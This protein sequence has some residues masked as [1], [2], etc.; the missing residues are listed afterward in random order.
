MGALS[1]SGPGALILL[2]IA[3][4]VFP[5]GIDR[6]DLGAF[7]ARESGVDSRLRAHLVASTLGPIQAAVFAMP[8]PLGTDNPAA[9][10]IR[11]TGIDPRDPGMTPP[12]PTDR[13]VGIVDGSAPAAPVFFP[14]VNREAKGDFLVE[15][16]RFDRLWRSGRLEDDD[17]GSRF[18]PLLDA[19]FEMRAAIGGSVDAP[20]EADFAARFEPMIDAVW[21]DVHDNPERVVD[22]DHVTLAESLDTALAAAIPASGALVPESFET[23]FYFDAGPGGAAY[24]GYGIPTSTKIAERPPAAWA[25]ARQAR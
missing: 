20:E 21:L 4:W 15:R 9:A 10:W 16:S 13:N 24:A 3:F 8:R 1:R 25:E 5:S 14:A 11:R 23:A 6:Q 18:A 22:A 12:F 2:V 17:F 7:V 19:V